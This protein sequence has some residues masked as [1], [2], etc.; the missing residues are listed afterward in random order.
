MKKKR[1]IIRVIGSVGYNYC[2]MSCKHFSI[3]CLHNNL[4]E[5]L[6]MMEDQDFNPEELGNMSCMRKITGGLKK[7]KLEAVYKSI[8][9]VGKS[10]VVYIANR[11]LLGRCSWFERR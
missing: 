8:S 9:P 10:G 1:W 7:Y 2:D 11:R 3:G 4:T 6:L 5:L